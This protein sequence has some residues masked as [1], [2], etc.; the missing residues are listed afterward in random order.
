MTIRYAVI[1]DER[2]GTGVGPALDDGGHWARFADSTV[3]WTEAASDRAGRSLAR[4]ARETERL[5]LVTQVGRAFQDEH[6]GLRPV[7]DRGRHLVITDPA[8]ALLGDLPAADDPHACWRVEP[9]P[10]DVVVVDLPAAAPARVDPAIAGLLAEL[11]QPLFAADVA[12]L[13]GF[14][15]RHS[16]SPHFLAAAGWAAARLTSLGFAATR[17]PISVG[18][19]T[20]ENVVGDRPG[21]GSGTRDLVLVTAHLDSINLAGGAGASAPG[22][23][24]NASGSAGVLELGRVLAGRSWRHDLRLILFGGEEQGLHGSQQYVAALPAADRARLRAVLNLDMIATRNT[25]SPTVLLEGAA[26]SSGL[27]ADLASAA[28]TYTGLRVETSLSPFASDHVPFIT[29]GLPAV[30]T[31]E[32]ADSANGHIHSA[33]DRLEFVD[34]A[35]AAQIMRM[36]LAALAAWLGSMATAP[37]PAGPVVSWGPGRLDL[38]VVGADSALYHKA[39]DGSAWHPAVDGFEHLGGT[40]A[41]P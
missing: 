32:G 26:V 8:G 17:V 27:I 2:A 22:A 23:D 33:N 4:G 25:A 28:A 13:A 3:V 18:A 14:P 6:P 40:I 1:P 12:F 29:A 35:Y 24:D 30:L 15:T 21:A 39:W 7:L 19:G 11:S 20:S 16:L 10:R 31:I 38:F 9:L 34:P 36:N 41:R 5:L 37:R